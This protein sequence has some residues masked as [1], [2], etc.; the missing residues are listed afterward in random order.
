MNRYLV[1]LNLCILAV[2]LHACPAGSK[3]VVTAEVKMATQNYAD[4]AKDLKEEYLDIPKD[5]VRRKAR[6]SFLLGECYKFSN[7][8]QE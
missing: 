7:D 8:L 2:I 3:E 4:A 6:V 5:S 1:Y